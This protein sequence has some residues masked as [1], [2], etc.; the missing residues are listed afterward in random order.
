M[1]KKKDIREDVGE[2]SA[3]FYTTALFIFIGVWRLRDKENE[4]E[5]AMQNTAVH[6]S[7]WRPQSTLQKTSMEIHLSMNYKN[8]FTRLNSSFLP[9][10]I[11]STEIQ[12]KIIKKEKSFGVPPFISQPETIW[13]PNF[14]FT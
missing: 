10:R 1:L 8:K 4:M 6:H 7:S 12:M 2:L 13:I 5:W 3:C 9:I 11:A 14:Q